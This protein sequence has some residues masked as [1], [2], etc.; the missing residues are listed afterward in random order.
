MNLADIWPP[1]QLTFKLALISTAILLLLCTPLSWFLARASFR[2]K[3]LLE[4][5]IALPIVLPPTVLGF[6]LLISFSP[7]G[8]LGSIVETLGG[9]QLTFSFT[10]LVLGSILYS[11][12][13]VSQPLQ[14]AFRE[15]SQEH[16]D[17]AATLGAGPIDRFITVALPISK[18]GFLTA[19]ALGF[20]H[21]VGEFGVVLMIGGNIPG[22]TQVTS[23]AIYENVETLQYENAHYLSGILLVLS[24]ALLA[25]V[26][27]LNQPWRLARK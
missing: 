5:L 11:F 18:K 3:A 8:W 16:L 1:L 19:A 13:F 12:P 26:Y 17:A 24:F 15:V 22:E 23:I 4:A 14:N 9:P 7:D 6:Y 20:A 27:S 21:T 10:G 2:G 25:F